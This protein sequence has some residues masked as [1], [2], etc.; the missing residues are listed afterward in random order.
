MH[1]RNSQTLFSALALATLTAPF[2]AGCAHHLGPETEPP[3]VAR[4]LGLAGCDV[5]ESM[6]RYQTLDYADLLGNP[7]LADSQ[8]WAMAIS[9]MQP[10]DELRYVYCKNNGDN[11]F[12]LFRGTSL[13]FKFGGMLY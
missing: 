12:G 13:L 7:N 2:I 11:F 6:R 5:S 3:R 9:M 1:P 10:G 4:K 8:E